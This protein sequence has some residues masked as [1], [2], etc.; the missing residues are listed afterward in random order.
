M[1]GKREK[2]GWGNNLQETLQGNTKG[3]KF[4]PIQIGGLG[5]EIESEGMKTPEKETSL[6]VRCLRIQTKKISDVSAAGGKIH[7]VGGQNGSRGAVL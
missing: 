6:R 4:C 3:S 5:S 1:G 2:G 7:G